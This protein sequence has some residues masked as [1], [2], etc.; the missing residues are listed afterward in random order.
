MTAILDAYGRPITARPTGRKRVRASYDAAADTTR[1]ERHWANAD[2]KSAAAATSH[3]VREKLRKRARYA[4]HESN[5]YAAGIVR[6]LA[7][8]TIGTGPRLQLMIPQRSDASRQ[9]EREFM[10]WVYESRLAE[11]LRTKRIAKAVDGES[12]AAFVTNPALR[13]RVQ[14]DLALIECDRVKSPWWQL[15]ESEENADGIEFDSYGNPVRYTVL[16]EHPGGDFLTEFGEFDVVAAEDMIH[17]FRVDRPGQRRGVPEIAPALPLFALLQRFTLATLHAAETAASYAGVLYTD[18]PDP[19]PEGEESTD[20][21]PGDVIEVEHNSLLVLHA[22]R[23]LSQMKAEHPTT[24][25]EMFK[26]ETLREALRCLNMPY[27]VGSGDSSKYNYASGRLDHQTYDRAIKIEQDYF[28]A[29]C[30]DR[31]FLRWLEEAMLI[32]G[33]LPDELPPFAE[34]NWVWFFDGRPHVDPLKEAAAAETLANSCRQTEKEYWAERGFDWEEQERQIA[35]ELG[36]TVQKLR[37]LK[38]VKRFATASSLSDLVLKILDEEAAE[39]L[40]Q[41]REAA[42][43][44]VANAD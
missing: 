20:S 23:K 7:N 29:A 19:D 12:F 41:E 31:T 24:N 28:G 1:N 34:W 32:P 22:G 2:G 25:H 16:R 18:E 10:L 9:I 37:K 8:D 40:S 5:S 30:L 14:L 13:T 36:V 38:A 3:E 15:D 42:R 44:E 43:E 26:R 33:Y 6:T 27:N 35:K 11:K 17:L 21:E 4:C 39:E